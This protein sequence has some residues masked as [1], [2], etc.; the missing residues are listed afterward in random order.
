[1]L[2]VEVKA[3]WNIMMRSRLKAGDEIEFSGQRVEA[4]LSGASAPTE[5]SWEGKE[6]GQ[7]LMYI[8]G[9]HHCI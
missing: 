5:N 2:I 7:Y 8:W 6:I 4:A 1:M 3:E 9:C